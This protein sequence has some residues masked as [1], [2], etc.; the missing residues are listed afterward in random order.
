MWRWVTRGLVLT[1]VALLAPCLFAQQPF[2][3]AVDA[4]DPEQPQS[5]LV[6]VKGWVYDPHQVTKIELWVDDQYQHDA[7]MF[8]PRIDV[9]EAY[10][11][12]REPLASG[13]KSV[14]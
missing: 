8:L 2:I 12:W 7:V 6:L 14:N 5:G 3:G 1:F 4:P 11:D 10:P 13:G 9:I